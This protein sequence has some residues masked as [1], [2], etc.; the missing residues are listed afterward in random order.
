MHP[1]TPASLDD[2]E[3]ASI[4]AAASKLLN[5]EMLRHP[6]SYGHQGNLADP[7]GASED[8][9]DDSQGEDLKVWRLLPHL[10]DLPEAM[11]KKLPLSA[12]FQLNA[13]MAK[14]SKHAAKM[15]VNSRL[16]ANAQRIAANPKKMAQ[17]EDNRREILHKARFLGGTSC[18]STELWLA[19]KREIG[20]E[21]I[22]AIGNYDLDSVGCGGSVTPKGWLAIHN[23]ASQELKLKL[24][25]LPNVAGNGLSAKKVNLDGEDEALSIGDSLKEI[26]D[27]EGYKAALNTAREA[28]H[29]ALPWNRSIC[30]IVGFMQN[31]NYLQNDLAG[32]SRRASILTEFTDYVFGRNALNWENGHPFL[33]A[34]DLAHVWSNWKGKRAALFVKTEEKREKPSSYKKNDICRKYN[35]GKCDK[36][37]EKECKTPYGRTLRHVCNKYAGAG[38]MCEKSHPRTDH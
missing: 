36:Q 16:A 15:S 29:S 35:V 28:M 7:G 13:A 33:T 4:S 26:A 12:I 3:L 8:E 10:K 1:G 19:A 22:T 24:F 20:V 37:A 6:A 34:D 32:N 9:E 27:L 5:S 2:S 25:Y 11:L 30:A 31:S 18:S 38:K 23:P 21:G 17:G 14:E